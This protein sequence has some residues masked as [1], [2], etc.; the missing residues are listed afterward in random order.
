M[1]YPVSLSAFQDLSKV[2]GTTLNPSFLAAERHL[3]TNIGKED[4]GWFD[5]SEIDIMAEALGKPP[6]LKTNDFVW[7]DVYYVL[8][9]WDESD[10]K[11]YVCY[12]KSFLPVER[13]G[14][15][16]K[17][18]ILR[19]LEGLLAKKD[20]YTY[21]IM[22]RELYDYFSVRIAVDS[23]LGL[24]SKPVPCWIDSRT[25]THL[26]VPV[27]LA[28]IHHIK[29]L[30]FRRLSYNPHDIE[31]GMGVRAAIEKARLEDEVAIEEIVRKEGPITNDVVSAKVGL[32][33]STSNTALRRL[34]DKGRIIIDNTK[35]VHSYS[36]P[37]ETATQEPVVQEV[38]QEPAVEEKYYDAD[39][40]LAQ[41]V[42]KVLVEVSA[43]RRAMEA[44]NDHYCKTAAS[45]A[46]IEKNLRRAEVETKP[47]KLSSKAGMFLSGAL[48]MGAALIL[49]LGLGMVMLGR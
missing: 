43:M 5:Q 47:E 21:W 22:A 14:K 41:D 19:I 15:A 46:I 40:G 44:M 31:N 45:I 1:K 37:E 16:R 35:M 49:V 30:V 17:E 33:Y 8:T 39:P 4:F 38:V 32:K 20:G 48:F 13:D 36:V 26:A 9:D 3:K 24:R 6:N 42:V 18:Q 11:S 29:G 23:H 28:L 27:T 34:A 10:P 7:D 12:L 25:S 2:Y